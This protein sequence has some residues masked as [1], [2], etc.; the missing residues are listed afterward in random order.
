MSRRSVRENVFKLIYETDISGEVN[1][2]SVAEATKCERESELNDDPI[3]AMRQKLISP[4]YP[5]ELI[6]ESDKSYFDK[7]FYGINQN[8]SKIEDIIAK[9]AHAFKLERLY[10]VDRAILLVAIYEILYMD[11]IPYKVSI[12]EA[13]ELAKIYS[14]EKSA[15]YINGILASVVKNPEELR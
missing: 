15:S 2:L 8:L 12:N 6:D 14:T 1:E 13:V 11:D 3:V 7:V 5:F 10:R 9:Y 4:E